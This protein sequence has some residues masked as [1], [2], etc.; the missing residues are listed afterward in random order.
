MEGEKYLKQLQVS[1]SRLEF[2][3]ESNDVFY[4]SCETEGGRN[5]I[6]IIAEPSEDRYEL[7]GDYGVLP[8]NKGINTFLLYVS[9]N[10]QT[11][12]TFEISVIVKEDKSDAY[13]KKIL[14]NNREAE[15][16]FENNVFLHYYFRIPTNLEFVEIEPIP[17]NMNAEIHG[18]F[19]TVAVEQG[20]NNFLIEIVSKDQRD[21][22]TYLLFIERED[23]NQDEIENGIL[24]VHENIQSE[25]MDRLC[26]EEEDE[27]ITGET[28]TKEEWLVEG[29]MNEV[30]LEADSTEVPPE[31]IGF[32]EFSQEK[33]DNE[34]VE[35]KTFVPPRL[36]SLIISDGRLIPEFEPNI[37]DYTIEMDEF[38]ERITID[39][40]AETEEMILEGDLG[41]SEVV[42]GENLF[43]ISCTV[44]NRS[45]TQVYK[46]RLNNKIQPVAS[47]N[48]KEGKEEKLKKR[49]QKLKY[50]LMVVRLKTIFSS[51]SPKKM[52]MR[53][54]VTAIFLI[55]ASLTYLSYMFVL[56]PLKI[57]NSSISQKLLE[58]SQRR[59]TIDNYLQRKDQLQTELTEYEEQIKAFAERY[60]K[61]PSQEE[62]LEFLDYLNSRVTFDYT[63]VSV[64]TE[65]QVTLNDIRA[66]VEDKKL[67]ELVGNV[68]EIIPSISEEGN[69]VTEIKESGITGQETVKQHLTVNTATVVVRGRYDDML[70]LYSLIYNKERNILMDNITLNRVS[71][72]DFS[73]IATEAWE[74]GFDMIFYCY[75]NSAAGAAE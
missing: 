34:T 57:K 46:L 12:K 64:S 51:S 3:I 60:P 31:E 41:E 43:Y 45:V 6:E 70:R 19:G 53:D 26:G 38:G 15:A 48:E 24:S 11:V 32:P 59:I 36:M 7:S 75:S 21:R 10:G 18:E 16:V 28:E 55:M 29:L 14:V 13:L 44:K 71:D 4:Y 33:K 74:L 65:E 20:M 61:L 66:D 1:N 5:T 30:N 56:T 8:V 42:P 40:V 2:I 22:E 68:E 17:G 72:M 49:Q 35:E 52:R 63:S 23:R 39:A 47:S 27:H 9:V 37:L 50:K 25:V 54:K 67:H 69:Q 58:V 73:G 62:I